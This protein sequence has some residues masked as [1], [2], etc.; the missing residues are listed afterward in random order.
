MVRR[1]GKVET[2]EKISEIIRISTFLNWWLGSLDSLSIDLALSWDPITSLLNQLSISPQSEGFL[3]MLFVTDRWFRLDDAKSNFFV[4]LLDLF[5]SLLSLLHIKRSDFFISDLSLYFS[6]G[7][8]SPQLMREVNSSNWTSEI[9]LP[10]LHFFY[11]SYQ[12]DC[13]VALSYSLVHALL[14][15][16]TCE[17]SSWNL[18][19]IARTVC[20]NHL[21]RH[22][23]MF[24]VLLVPIPPSAN[25]RWLLTKEFQLNRCLSHSRALRTLFNWIISIAWLPQ[26]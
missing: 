5:F 17:L 25:I 14:W 8:L 20:I 10:I 19:E 7:F 18:L 9:F 2:V 4:F 21:L 22:Y 13:F 3:Y 24:Y 15:S 11:P 26:I 12:I 1:V 23:Q 16:I 6:I